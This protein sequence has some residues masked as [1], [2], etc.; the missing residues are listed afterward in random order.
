MKDWKIIYSLSG[1]V[2]RVIKGSNI[3]HWGAAT[4]YGWTEK[5]HSMGSQ[6]EQPGWQ[7]KTQQCGTWK[8]RAD[9]YQVKNEPLRHMLPG[10]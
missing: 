7:E 9:D 6:M 2:I 10:F 8:P 4:F 3:G 5:R 1:I